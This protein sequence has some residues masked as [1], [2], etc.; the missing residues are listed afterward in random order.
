MTTVEQI[1]KAISDDVQIFIRDALK[2][3][4]L[5]NSNLAKTYRTQ[6]KDNIISMIFSHYVI[7][8]QSGRKAGSRKPPFNAIY[9]WAKSKGINTSN[10]V[11]WK[12]CSAIAHRG[13]KAR[14]FMDIVFKK[15]DDEWVKKWAN[16]IFNAIIQD[17][18][19]YFN[20]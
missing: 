5:Q 13:I 11:I 14:P 7:Y 2:Q 16:Q 15:A 8:V 18:N 1:Y 9:K 10:E 17:L 19:G 20:K 12:I 3:Y 4:N 6:V